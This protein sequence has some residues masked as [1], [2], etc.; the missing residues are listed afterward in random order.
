[1]QLTMAKTIKKSSRIPGQNPVNPIRDV[2]LA[3]MKAHPQL[4]RHPAEK[5]ERLY[6]IGF[7]TSNGRTV[8]LDKMSASKQPMWV[9]LADFPSHA[10]PSI[11][12]EF[13]SPEEG[14]NSN[15]RAFGGDFKNG[16]LIRL[17]PQSCSEALAIVDFLLGR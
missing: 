11:D 16:H 4:R 9:R 15:L 6:I 10:L 3:S 8:A 12:R 17:Y 7:Q 13:Y 2:I 1:M 14:R 5:K